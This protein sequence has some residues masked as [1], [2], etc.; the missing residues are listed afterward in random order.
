ML[1]IW[2]IVPLV[3]VAI[4]AS[5]YVFTGLALQYDQ[6]LELAE[7]KAADASLANQPDLVRSGWEEVLSYL[8]EAESYKQTVDT[9]NLKA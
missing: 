1:P 4:A 7:A 3:V 9:V 5:V 2:V 6:Y 8:E